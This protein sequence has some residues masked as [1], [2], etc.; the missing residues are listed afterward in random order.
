MG[1]SDPNNKIENIVNQFQSQ[2]PDS[3][4]KF[5]NKL[6]K[7]DFAIIL[8]NDHLEV[9]FS[10]QAFNQILTRHNIKNIESLTEINDPLAVQDFLK[11]KKANRLQFKFELSNKYHLGYFEIFQSELNIENQS[12]YLIC[13]TE[14]TPNKRISKH[15]SRLLYDQPGLGL[16]Y[17]TPDGTVI[18]YNNI[19]AANL[20]GVPKDFA[21]KKLFDLFPDERA[22]KCYRRM[23]KCLDSS[24]SIHF[25]DEV[26]LPTGIKWFKSTYSKVLNDRKETVGVLIVSDDITFFKK[27][28][29]EIQSAYELLSETEK[30]AKSGSWTSNPLTGEGSWSKGSYTIRGASPELTGTVENHE[31]FMHPDDIEPYR[32]QFEANI[33][34]GESEFKQFFRLVDSEGN[35]K[36][37]EAHYEVRRNDKGEAVFITGI[38]KDVTELIE[39]QSELNK[40]KEEY[41]ALSDA[42]FECIFISRKGIC[43]GQNKT[44]ETTFGYTNDEAYGKPGTD[45][46]I[47]E[48]R[49]MVVSKIMN[50][51]TNP[52]RA[53]ALRKDGSSFPCEIQAK[54][55]EENG[56]IIRYTALRDISD[57]VKAEEALLKSEERFKLAMNA[58]RDGLYDW[59]IVTNEVYYSPGWKKM[60]GYEDHELPNK[61]SVWEELTDPQDLKES[62]KKL[63]AHFNKETERFEIE[64]RMKHKNGHYIDILSR[65][66][67]V[68][69]NEGKAVRMV[70]T[71]VDISESKKTHSQIEYQKKLTQQYLDVAGTMLIALDTNQNVVMMNPKGCEILGYELEDIIGKNWFDNFIPR[72]NVNEIKKVFNEAINGDIE[73][74]EY[75]ENP[76]LTKGGREKM[77]AWHNSVVKDEKGKIFGLFS[78]GNDIT[79]EINSKKALEESE[80]TLRL[81]LD[82]GRLGLYDF[83]I[84]TGKIVVNDHYAT[85]LGYDPDTFV[86]TETDWTKRLHPDDL[87]KTSELYKNYILGKIDEYKAEF[88]LK[89]S[90]NKWKWIYSQG[91]IV[92][93]TEK[94]RPLRMIGTHTDIDEMKKAQEIIIDSEEK[95]KA[96]YMNAPLAYQS[97]NING[98]IIDVN[99]QWLKTLAYERDEVIGKHFGEFLNSE[100]KKH[101]R[102]KFPVFK[103]IGHVSDVR[104]NMITKTGDEIIV[105]FE[106]CIGYTKTGEFR[107]TY[108]TFKEITSE[109][110]ANE[111]LLEATKTLEIS[112]RKF[113]ELFEKSGDAVFILEGN[114]VVNGNRASVMLFGFDSF[115]QLRN[116][117]PSELSP[118]YQKPDRP[119]FEA[120]NQVINDTI[121]KG[122]KRFEWLHKNKKNEVFP[123]E[124]LL[125]YLGTNESGKLVTHA[126]IRDITQRK[127]E[128]LELINAKNKAEESDRLKSAFLA[129]MSHEIRTPMNGIL[130]FA[131]LLKEPQLEEGEHLQYVDVI[132]RSG[133]RM[134][135]IINDLIDIS[136]IEAQQ[137]EVLL[138]D[139][140]INEQ[141]KY[142]KTFF[143]PEALRKN[144][145][146]ST[147][148]PL[149]KED[150]RIHT[151]REKVYAIL[152]NLIK[153]A[154]K[155]TEKGKIEFGYED[156]GKELQFFVADTGIGIPAEKQATIFER[157]IQADMAHNRK[158][159]G[160]GLGLAI[161]KAYV[162][163]LGGK[164]WIDY[165]NSEGTKF[166]FTIPKIQQ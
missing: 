138:Q 33:K 116:K 163:I 12:L 19:A 22:E 149:N 60:L 23:N 34:S 148:T 118:E 11:N 158:Y 106:G 16:E 107:Q 48:D 92:E 153:N 68:F 69:D 111:K 44:A 27:A 131:E 63:E 1:Q 119:S 10:N 40:T 156:A 93:Y 139:T 70:G 105:S 73:L 101:F 112:E 164:I 166:S 55:F 152:T 32:K 14:P 97:L 109:I 30:I 117:M 100:S 20:G 6:N 144:L 77:I 95:Y 145:Q 78:S 123:C 132:E 99:P 57:R 49:E 133:K 146:L 143:K 102:E 98:R 130:G 129:N 4:L 17:Y 165:S 90:D 147:Y 151:D 108:C 86:E 161:V 13:Q 43:I 91:K 36:H 62:W 124:V 65:A 2:N 61:F 155:Y 122:T 128:E 54:I 103:S 113:R 80:E 83:N 114:K 31:K 162:E 121:K 74:V 135:N 94:G 50:N 51:V 46:I 120:M 66:N 127:K 87:Q 28:E 71:H 9:F 52:Y 81:A 142:L 115:E 58:S 47:P 141:I 64:F 140:A 8:V 104:F 137:M 157:F 89:T 150:S 126:V 88:R 45:W 134:L 72:K 82:S 42:S 26:L 59:N 21:G 159:E 24:D 25:V 125:T 84:R 160:A 75:Y 56:E 67:A 136:K 37:I 38:D 76:V 41:K 79:E 39:A 18:S 154:L 29:K 7:L 96:L 35:T 15:N 110:I 85:M 53:T 5:V 3:Y